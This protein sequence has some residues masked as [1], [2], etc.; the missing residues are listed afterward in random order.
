EMGSDDFILGRDDTFWVIQ[1]LMRLAAEKA[2][3]DVHDPQVILYTQVGQLGPEV[4]TELFNTLRKMRRRRRPLANVPPE[5]HVPYK[6]GNDA[7][8]FK[9]FRF[10]RTNRAVH[11][12][13][14]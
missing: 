8:F 12:P 11:H 7:L 14:S 2:G 3:V 1:T 9:L 10:F 5:L 4:G 6:L 13:R